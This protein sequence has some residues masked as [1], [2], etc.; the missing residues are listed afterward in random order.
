[1]K[2]QII[3][4]PKTWKVAFN[5]FY[6]IDPE[7]NNEADSSW[8]FFKEDILQLEN[9]VHGL[10]IDLGWYPEFSANGEFKLMLVKVINENGETIGNWESALKT[11]S[12]SNRVEIVREIEKWCIEHDKNYS[13]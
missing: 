2:L 8:E 1:M 6:E 9:D 10:L 7:L 12:S 11:F 13:K 5:E 4:L 3:N